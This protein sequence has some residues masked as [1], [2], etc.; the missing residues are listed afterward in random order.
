MDELLSNSIHKSVVYALLKAR[1]F[2]MILIIQ[3]KVKNEL[4]TSLRI[5]R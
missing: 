2:D 3:W 4:I 5:L 1:Y